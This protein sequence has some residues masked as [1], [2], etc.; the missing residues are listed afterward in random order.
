MRA[1][2][3]I[4]NITQSRGCSALLLSC[5]APIVYNPTEMEQEHNDALSAIYPQDLH[6]WQA[7]KCPPA[8][9]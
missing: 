7:I 4:R 1:T 3:N 8:L 2:F 5:Q 9:I 6:E